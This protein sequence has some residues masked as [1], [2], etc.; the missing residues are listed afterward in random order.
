MARTRTTKSSCPRDE[1]LVFDAF[2]VP[3]QQAAPLEGFRRF[4]RLQSIK[5]GMMVFSQSV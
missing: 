5:G 1:L 3:P 4:A 2:D